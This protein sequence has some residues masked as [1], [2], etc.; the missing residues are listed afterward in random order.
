MPELREVPLA[1]DARPEEPM[2]IAMSGYEARALDADTFTYQTPIINPKPGNTQ[3]SI[4]C[5]LRDASVPVT[6]HLYLDWIS[7]GGDLIIPVQLDGCTPADFAAYTS[8]DTSTTP[9]LVHTP[10]PRYRLRLELQA[11][12]AGATDVNIHLAIMTGGATGV[13]RS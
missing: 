8:N 12:G 7:V 2:I 11:T 10:P 9:I 3:I 1:Y 13:V 6:G 4:L 5:A